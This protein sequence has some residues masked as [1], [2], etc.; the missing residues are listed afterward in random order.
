MTDSKNKDL[1]QEFDKLEETMIDA[2]QFRTLEEQVA[3]MKRRGIDPSKT[4]KK[5]DDDEDD[6]DDWG[7]KTWREN[8][9]WE[10]K[11]PEDLDEKARENWDGDTGKPNPPPI[12]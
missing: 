11:T 7:D 3:E 5:W 1:K 6:D 8:G 10:P 9:K 2:D 12:V 4:Y